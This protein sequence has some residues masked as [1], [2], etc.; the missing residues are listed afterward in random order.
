MLRG[1]DPVL[2]GLDPAAMATEG[3]AAPLH[4]G[5]DRYFREQGW[6]E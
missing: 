4:P 6:L 3:L 5:A 1:L 2:A